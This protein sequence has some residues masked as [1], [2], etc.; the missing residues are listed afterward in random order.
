MNLVN[1]GYNV[2]C[3]HIWSKDKDM[4]YLMLQF[5]VHVYFLYNIIFSMPF[6][7]NCLQYNIYIH[8]SRFY[9]HLFASFCIFCIL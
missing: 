4:A 9:Y 6:I 1:Y 8:V 7:L 3:K 2:E 5:I